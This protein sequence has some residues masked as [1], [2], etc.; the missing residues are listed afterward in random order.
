MSRMPLLLFLP[1]ATPVRAA[2]AVAEE[3]VAAAA[4]EEGERGTKTTRSRL[5]RPPTTPTLPC[6]TS[7]STRPVT[8]STPCPTTACSTPTPTRSCP[9]SGCPTC[10]ARTP[11]SS[12]G[13][14]TQWVPSL[15]QA[16]GSLASTLTICLHLRDAK[17]S[18]TLVKT[19]E[20]L[21]AQK[22]HQVAS[23]WETFVIG[24]DSEGGDVGGKGWLWTDDRDE[25]LGGFP[26]SAPLFFLPKA[27]WASPPPQ[28]K[29]TF[30]C[31]K[32]ASDRTCK[33][34]RRTHS[35][36]LIIVSNQMN[37]RWPERWIIQRYILSSDINITF[38][39]AAHEYLRFNVSIGGIYPP[40]IRTYVIFR[41]KLHK[42]QAPYF[43]PL[44]FFP[45]VGGS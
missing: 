5:S 32:H 16:V 40:L 39:S 27:C 13:R 44:L 20:A 4:E 7:W 26:L 35:D 8:P 38:L 6:C 10:W 2:A 42:L 17:P 37:Y 19:M 28:S 9:P 12:Q 11:T 30:S 24:D 36:A 43:I 21:P 22:L 15:S 14:C 34:P 3:E 31:V 41:I 25:G 18:W 1:R 23:N 45:P 29:G 33:H